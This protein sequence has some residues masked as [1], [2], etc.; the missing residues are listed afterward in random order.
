MED[1]SARR[2]AG[3]D[4]DASAVSGISKRHRMQRKKKAQLVAIQQEEASDAVPSQMIE[5]EATD[6]VTPVV[7]EETEE[8]KLRRKRAEAR[9][10]KL[11]AMA[12]LRNAGKDDDAAVSGISKRHRIRRKKSALAANAISPEEQERIDW[13]QNV[14]ASVLN[15][16]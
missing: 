9:A 14:Y 7:K 15:S 1:I 2:N 13:K 3:K 16:E 5:E 10:K 12:R 4:D 11:E 8:E 6:A